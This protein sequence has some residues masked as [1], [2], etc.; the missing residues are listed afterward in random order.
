MMRTIPA[1]LVLC[2]LLAAAPQDKK[3]RTANEALEKVKY[4]VGEWKVSATPEEGMKGVSWDEEHS[5]EYVID[6]KIGFSE[7]F[8]RPGYPERSK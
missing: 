1:L 8:F 7:R 5:W 2:V 4:L 3:P 6:K